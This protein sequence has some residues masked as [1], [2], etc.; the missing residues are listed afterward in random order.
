MKCFEYGPGLS[1]HLRAL[2]H[3]WPEFNV[4]E[5]KIETKTTI[6]HFYFS[7]YT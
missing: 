3:P 4:V 7:K 2:N 6:L 1:I 5:T